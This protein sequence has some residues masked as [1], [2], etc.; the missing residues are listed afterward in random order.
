MLKSPWQHFYHEIPLFLDTL[1]W[2][3]S[4]LVRSEIL[5]LFINTFTTDHAYSR[6]YL[7][8]IYPTCSNAN[9]SKTENIFW[10]FHYIS[11]IYTKFCTL[12]KKRSASLLKYFGSY[13]LREMSLLESLRVPV[14]EHFCSGI[15][16]TSIKHCWSHHWSS[17]VINIHYS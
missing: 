4:L 7:R 11:K 1:S 13:W 15:A 6:H 16:V 17:F 2:K 12:R 14:L 9:I 8:E 5:L 3:T 10:I